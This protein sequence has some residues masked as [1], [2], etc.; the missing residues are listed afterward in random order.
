MSS[1]VRENEGAGPLAQLLVDPPKPRRLSDDLD[2][3]LAYAAGGP[4][5]VAE[6]EIALKARGFAVF[7]V[8]LALPFAFPI[9]IPGL[10]VPFGVLIGILGIRMACGQKPWL[11]RFILQRE[12][13][14]S[15]LSKIAG[16]G[17]RV[18]KFMEFCIR[19]RMHFLQR[20]PGMMNLIGLSIACGGFMLCL[21]LPPLIPFSNM[22]PGWAVLC[23]STG[24]MERDGLLVLAGHFLN[25]L[26]L[27]Y[28][29]ALYFFGEQGI[30]WL[31]SFF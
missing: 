3:L 22:L 21:P 15:V 6:I 28:F 26:A 12:I 2:D 16:G 10:S 17:M 20:W 13:S 5:T 27:V 11:P 23:L 29:G 25:L 9:A 1:D 18:A 14:Y 7:L 30:R 19:P 4:M 31:M 8:L 24:V